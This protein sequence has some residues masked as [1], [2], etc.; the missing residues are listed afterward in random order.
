MT[1]LNLFKK[2]SP[3]FTD[4]QRADLIMAKLGFPATVH[5]RSP[6]YS[7]KTPHVDKL[8]ALML[9]KVREGM[10][11]MGVSWANSIMPFEERARAILA[12]QWEIEHKHSRSLE[13]ADCF[14]IN[15]RFNTK[16]MTSYYEFR[17]E[18]IKPWLRDLRSSLAMRCRIARDWI[19]GLRNP[20]R[21]GA[22]A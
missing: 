3:K 8:R 4:E 2:P 9:R 14:P 21:E 19:C 7:V 10:L 17:P 5:V 16:T 12:V 15:R 13:C 1:D 18:R 22:A 11:D 20:Y 6:L